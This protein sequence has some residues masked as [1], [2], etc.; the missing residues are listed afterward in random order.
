MAYVPKALPRGRSAGLCAQETWD[1][2]CQDAPPQ[3]CM[4]ACI[5][6]S[7]HHM[8]LWSSAAAHGAALIWL[9]PSAA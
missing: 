3:P 5:D 6:V 9:G 4:W 8:K 7:L 2:H 1:W